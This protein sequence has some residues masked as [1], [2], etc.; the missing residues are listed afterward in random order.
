MEDMK[1]I[2]NV[3]LK[4]PPHEFTQTETGNEKLQRG[5]CKTRLQPFYLQ[6]RDSS[7][8]HSHVLTRRAQPL[9]PLA[10]RRTWQLRAKW[11]PLA[12]NWSIPPTRSPYL[13]VKVVPEKC[14]R[15]SL[16]AKMSFPGIVSRLTIALLGLTFLLFYSSC[17][18]FTNVLYCRTGCWVQNAVYPNS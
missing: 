12:T 11:P 10:H 15:K 2:L 16:L 7:K 14:C 6:S 18:T 8:S 1:A 4:Q 5:M 9:W 17:I 13:G 3:N